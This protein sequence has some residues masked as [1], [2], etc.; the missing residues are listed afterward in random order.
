MLEWQNTYRRSQVY[1]HE[2]IARDEEVVETND[3][4]EIVEDVTIPG[5]EPRQWEY[6]P[7][8]RPEIME[9]GKWEYSPCLRPEIMERVSENIVPVST[10]KSW[11][12]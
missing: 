8:L 11:S 2:R 6:S 12:G 10:L 9:Q 1:G 5:D 3:V 4:P 7:R